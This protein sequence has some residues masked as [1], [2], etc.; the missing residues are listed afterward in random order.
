MLHTIWTITLL[1]RSSLRPW[2]GHLLPNLALVVVVPWRTW[3]ASPMVRTAVTIQSRTLAVVQ[4]W[5]GTAVA[6]LLAFVGL[7]LSVCWCWSGHLA[8]IASLHTLN[9]VTVNG[10][11]AHVAG[12]IRSFDVFTHWSFVTVTSMKSRSG[13]RRNGSVFCTLYLRFLLSSSVS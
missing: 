8:G 4:L 5:T 1:R 13:E 3:T 9:R 12:L 6:L 2:F 11:C 10:V 7:V